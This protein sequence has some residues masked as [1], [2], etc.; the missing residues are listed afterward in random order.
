M[1]AKLAKLNTFVYPMVLG[2]SDSDSGVFLAKMEKAIPTSVFERLTGLVEEIAE[3]E[4]ASNFKNAAHTWKLDGSPVTEMDAKVQL[5]LEDALPKIIS[6]PVLGEEMPQAKQEA[7]WK[8]RDA[9]IWCVDPIDG[10]TNFINGIPYFAISIS[11][12]RGSESIIGLVFNP[13]SKENYYAEKGGG[14]YLDGARLRKGSNGRSQLS[15]CVASVDLKRLPHS[16]RSRLTSAPPYAS[17][18]NFGAASLEWCHVASGLFDLYIHGSQKIWDLAAG[19]LV[20]SESGGIMSS[21]AD[22]DLWLGEEL[23][24]SVLASGSQIIFKQLRD[25]LSSTEEI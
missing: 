21:F 17:Q 12:I 16:L 7:I 22:D 14:A 15:E 8:Q 19:S 5:V 23:H 1:L 24:R 10:T 9:G 20:L 3:K 11:F 2:I 18:R 6:A 4:L 25:W 13:M